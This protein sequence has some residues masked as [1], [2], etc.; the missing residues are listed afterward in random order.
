MC[1]PLNLL[2]LEEL[3]LDKYPLV[4][5]LRRYL[6]ENIADRISGLYEEE[7]ISDTFASDLGRLGVLSAL[8]DNKDPV[9]VGQIFR[10]IE[11]VDSGL[12]SFVSVQ[13]ALAGFAISTYGSKQQK[14]TYLNAMSSGS[15]IASF[16]LTEPQ[17]GSDPASMLTNIE[18]KPNGKLVLN[19]HKYWVTNAPSADAIVV[20]AKLDGKVQGVLV[21]AN[22]NGVDIIPIKNKL[23][24][25]VSQSSEVKF[26]DVQ[27]TELDLM[28]GATSLGKALACLNQARLGI[29]WGVLGAMEDCIQTAV[30]FAKSRVLFAKPLASFQ[31]TQEKLHGMTSDLCKAQLLAVQVTRLKVSDALEPFQVSLAKQNNV[32][33]A[34]NAARSARQ[35]LGGTGI[36]AES[37]V[38]RHACNLETVLTYE[39][40]NEIHKLVV[41]MKLTGESAFS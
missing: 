12:R 16:A 17:G 22:T 11:R 25:R 21:P 15:K 20:W 13:C 7:K 10:E 39:G 33:V 18:R 35:I 3:A 32:E 6:Q 37:K 36:L 26:R 28:P 2:Q 19:G 34:L 9:L 5:E 4:R 8:I 30:S 1:S 14:E 24:L 40:T 31:L 29:A 41:G 27:L 23:S 38:M